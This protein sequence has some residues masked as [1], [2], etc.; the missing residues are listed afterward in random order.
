VVPDSI[1]AECALLKALAA[2]FVM[3]QTGIA[4]RQ[5]AQRRLLAELVS[6]V[7][8]R[9]PASLDRGLAAAWDRAGDTDGAGR[10]AARVRVVIDQVA[11]LTDSSAVAWHRR[12]ARAEPGQ[13]DAFVR[14]K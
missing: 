6:A 4:Q 11:Q 10:D 12:L 5:A 13:T 1:A 2:H 14:P 7:H 3:R 9:A 8:D